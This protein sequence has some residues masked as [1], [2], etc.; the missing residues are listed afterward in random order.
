MH[1]LDDALHREQRCP[2][3]HLPELDLVL[4]ALEPALEHLPLVVRRGVAEAGTEHEAVELRLGQRIRP[5][6]LDRVLRRKDEERRL[7]DV[8][9]AVDRD[10]PLLHRLEQRSLGLRRSPV[11]LVGKEDVGEDGAGPELE[12][13]V[14]LVPDRRSGD[15]RRQE[16]RRELDA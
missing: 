6:V 2:V 7:E 1:V 13:R 8:G 16:V 15:V 4:A 12:R 14:A 5:F 9:H 3:D 10:L 11:D